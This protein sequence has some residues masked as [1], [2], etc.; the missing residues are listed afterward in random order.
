[1]VPNN[2]IKG[3]KVTGFVPFNEDIFTEDEFLP[4]TVTDR[5]MP[6]ETPI[7]PENPCAYENATPSSNQIQNR[8]ISPDTC[9]QRLLL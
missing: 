5:P 1:M 3:F 2:I 7:T 6:Q 9:P 8:P 4:A